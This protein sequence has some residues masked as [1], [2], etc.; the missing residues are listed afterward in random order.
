M[1]E[2]GYPVSFEIS[3]PSAMFARPDT[4][5][6]PLSYPMPTKSALKS[7]FECVVFAKDAYFEPQRVEICRPIVFHKYSTNYG[8]P[9]RKSGTSNFQLFATVL[10]N[11][12]YKVHGVILAFS[13]PD[14]ENNPQHQLQ[15]VFTRRL[16]AGQLYTMPFLGWKEFVPDY[17]GPLRDS[18][19][20]DSSINLTVASMLNS[21]YDRPTN[22]LIAPEFA[23]NAEIVKGVM[24]YA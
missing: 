24:F 7:M 23:Q 5:S 1:I 2:K 9:L 16:A 19:S 18:T 8:G 14:S 3:G 12:C 10:E 22:G 4:G 15:E 13:S 6:S 17:F 21:M 20:A 11:V